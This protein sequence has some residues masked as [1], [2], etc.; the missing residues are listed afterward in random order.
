MEAM[1]ERP[2]PRS[3]ALG[4][5]GAGMLRAPQLSALSEPDR[6]VFESLVAPDHYL[7]RALGSV[8]FE[9]FRAVLSASY[10][11][12]QGR[13]AE[14]PVRMLKLGFLQFHDN[15]SDRQVIERAKTD[16]AYRYFLDLRLTDSLPDPSLLSYFRGRLGVE[17]HRRVFN[18]LV[19]Q[20]RAQGL[21]R[22]R[23]RLK[24]ATHV[25]ADVAIPTALALVAQVRERLLAVAKPFDAL[26][27]EGE[28]ARAE[29]IHES[30][31]GGND[32]ARLV[33][34][35]TH[36]R[37]ILAWVD[38]LQPRE[39][40]DAGSW[41]ALQAARRL[42]HKILADQDNPGA[43][44]RTRSVVDPDARRGKHG[45]WYDG[46]LVDVMMAY[47]EVRTEHPKIE[48]KLSELVRRHGARRARCRGLWRVR[49]QELMTAM[50]VNVKRLVLLLAL[51]SCATRPA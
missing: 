17:G 22:D 36:L 4:K 9:R 28:R 30:T 42:G 47:Q 3:S 24:D 34:R 32:E 41:S 23:L 50:V 7:C 16:V 35:V 29:M 8:D 26:R 11:P 44:N 19:A 27:V 15:R 18:E 5:Q 33:A 40:C 2:C 14:D 45:D 38:A 13:P 25:I 20:A 6:L 37:E 43:G 12:D 51:P 1:D 48:R 49:C 31:A 10:S 21:I 39:R 46:Y